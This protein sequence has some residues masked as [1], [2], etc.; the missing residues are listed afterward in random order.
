MSHLEPWVCRHLARRSPAPPTVSV[1]LT[2][3]RLAGTGLK[4]LIHSH[5]RMI[6]RLMWTLVGWLAKV[7]WAAAVAE[8]TG[9]SACGLLPGFESFASA[10]HT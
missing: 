4:T 10:S 8:D 1:C 5:R 6:T 2:S 7:S 9:W 3:V